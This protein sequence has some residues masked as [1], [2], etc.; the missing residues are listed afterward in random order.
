MFKAKLII[1][2]EIKDTI[3]KYKTAE[4]TKTTEKT[5]KKNIVS[6]KKDLILMKR[7]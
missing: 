4:K 5:F 1:L 6:K 2:N 3:T 7:L